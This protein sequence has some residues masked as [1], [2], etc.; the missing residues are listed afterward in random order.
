MSVDILRF[1]PLTIHDKETIESV[2]A[3]HDPYSDFH[4]TSMF[5]WNTDESAEFCILGD[6]LIIKLPD[7][8]SGLPVFSL[9]GVN[10]ITETLGKLSMITDEL[11]FVPE[12]V[13]DRIGDMDCDTSI[14][15]DHFDYIYNLEDLVKM[16][17]KSYRAVRN[18]VNQFASRHDNYSLEF[19]D[20]GDVALCEEMREVMGSWA[21]WKSA[22]D[23]VA[24]LDV[25][26]RLMAH[27]K[28]LDVI[29]VGI[30]V[31][32]KLAAFSLH[33]VIGKSGYAICHLQKTVPDYRNIDAFLTYQS[34]KV[35]Y[36]RGALF[37]NWEQ[38]LGLL[39][40]RQLKES[41]RPSRYL[42]KYRVN[43]HL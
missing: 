24:E 6:S 8:T 9:I 12:L 5:C 42:E 36:E 11:N 43:F 13:I 26:E 39:G 21:R 18:K 19:L 41:Y 14:Q 17:G 10:N 7:Y 34:S 31:D 27:H 38:D 23:N 30:R 16:K 28:R 15:R 35:L 20:M 33:E 29:G 22:G 3:S 37:V 32:K 1:H 25:L 2:V 40:L 4:F